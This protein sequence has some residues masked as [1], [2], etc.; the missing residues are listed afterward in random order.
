MNHTGLDARKVDN[1]ERNIFIVSAVGTG[2]IPKSAFDDALFRVGIHNFNLMPLSSVIPPQTNIIITKTYPR[3]IL[4]GTMQP[5]VLAH[6]E[7]ES[8]SQVISAGIGWM[9]AKEG[10]VFVEVSGTW[11]GDTTEAQL[12]SSVEELSQRRDWNWVQS[13]QTRVKETQ[14]ADK[15]ACVLV[16]AVYDFMTV[17]GEKLAIRTPISQQYLHEGI[18]SSQFS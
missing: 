8:R 7:S 16:C 2:C 10:G 1:M 12:I 13:C 6:H 9:L 14:V 5:V 18:S 11:D 17:W 15:A 4:P 3:E